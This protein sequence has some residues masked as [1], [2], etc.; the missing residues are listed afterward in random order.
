[1]PASYSDDDKKNIKA[2]F[3]SWM[4]GRKATGE[5]HDQTIRSTR[6]RRDDQR[7]CVI[8]Q[9]LAKLKLKDLDKMVGKE[10]D[11][12]L[13][14]ALKKRLEEFGDKPE[15]A[16]AEPFRK[17]TNDGR[18]GPVVRAVK[19]YDSTYS[20]VEVRD[21]L[22]GNGGMVRVDVYT[23][24]GKFYLVPQYIANVAQHQLKTKAIVQGKAE[25]EWTQIDDSFD[26]CFSLCRNDLIKVVT[27]K[28]D[29]IF[30]YYKGT[31][32]AIGTI[33]VE[34]HDSSWLKESIGVKTCN[35]IEKF[36]VTP[37]GEFYKVRKEPRPEGKAD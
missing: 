19:V 30:G 36:I 3:V 8:S 26:F 9:P 2:I 23:K 29:I 4:P 1:M 16:F 6:K 5:A 20:G 10:R 21:G 14:E 17:P 25:S 11:T 13:Y 33:D 22:A 34:A 28:K 31:N 35:S 18:P 32:R 37:L 7:G 24:G 12:R 15:K 27:A